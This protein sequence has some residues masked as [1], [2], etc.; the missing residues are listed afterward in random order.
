V[1]AQV[2]QSLSMA[3]S[4]AQRQIGQGVAQSEVIA[5]IQ[6]TPGVI[7]VEMT[8][9]SRQGEPASSPLSPV[10][11][12]AS[13]TAGQQGTPAGAELLTIDPASQGNF[14]AAS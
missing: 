10:L 6:Q 3:F 11:L 13:P 2:W 12:A 8:I 9:F 4:F 1:I 14:E 5:V 7:A